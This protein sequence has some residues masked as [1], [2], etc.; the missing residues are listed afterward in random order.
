M[1]LS[2]FVPLRPPGRAA[3]GACAQPPIACRVRSTFRAARAREPRSPRRAAAPDA[4]DNV[5]VM[6]SGT[7]RVAV[8]AASSRLRPQRRREE[9]EDVSMAI[10]QT[11]LPMF[12]QILYGNV[13]KRPYSVD[14]AVNARTDV[15]TFKTS[16]PITRARMA[17]SRCSCSRSYQITVQDLDGLIRIV[18]ANCPARR[19]FAGAALRQDAAAD[20]RGAAHR[21]PVCRA[22]CRQGQRPDARCCARCW[23]P[24]SRCRRT[25]DRNALLLSGT[26]ADLRTALELIQSLDQPRMRGSIARRLTPAFLNAQRIQ[27]PAGRSADRAGLCGRYRRRRQYA[28]PADADPGD[29][30]RDGLRQHRSVDGTGAALGARTRPADLAQTQNGLYTY[31]V[32]YADAQDLATTLGE[33]LGSRDRVRRAGTAAGAATAGRR[34]RSRRRAPRAAAAAASS[35]TARPIR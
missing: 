8:S 23:A 34:R 21:V 35:S 5:A 6:P 2:D 4:R 3:A 22:R 30:Q 19:D 27:Q 26:Q 10:E 25:P 17:E 15:V 31:P 28:D 20:A 14:P 16:R 11:P 13:L 18:P 29:R 9:P 24:A 7:G 32:K 1:K 33:V 12:I